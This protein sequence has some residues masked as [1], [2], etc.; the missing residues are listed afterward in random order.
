MQPLKNVI[1]SKFFVTILFLNIHTNLFSQLNHNDSLN[2][3]QTMEADNAFGNN[4]KGKIIQNFIL[5]DKN[6]KLFTSDSLQSK[7]T[8]INFWFDGCHPCFAEFEALE[9]FY[10]KNKLRKDFQFISITRDPDSVIDRIRKE[11]DLTY[12]IFHL[13]SDSCKNLKFNT[14]Y[15]TNWIVGKN[16]KIVYSISGGSNDPSDADKLLNYFIQ[17]ELDKQLK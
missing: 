12:P 7:I 14:G 11:H 5:R 15:P 6:G 16:R 10:I 8:F 1:L 2:Y 3:S 9:K 13:S 17:S 4:S